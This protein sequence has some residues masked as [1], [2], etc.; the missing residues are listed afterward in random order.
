M[1]PS[2]RISTRTRRRTAAAAGAAPPAVDYGFG[3]GGA[4][5]PSARRVSI[6]P[7]V[8]RSP[9]PL[10]VVTVPAPAASPALT[11]PIPSGP[12]H[13]EPVGTPLL[14]LPP[15]LTP[16]PPQ[17]STWMPSALL[18]NFSSGILP[19]AIRTLTACTSNRPSLRA[20]PPCVTSLLAGRHAYQP[21]VCRVFLRTS[22]PPAQR[23]RSLLAKAGYTPLTTAS[24]CSS[25]NRLRNPC[26]TRSTRWDARLVCWTMIVFTFTYHGSCTVGSC[27]LVIRQ[28]PAISAPRALCE[29]SGVF[30]GGL[31]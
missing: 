17:R 3:P 5:R 1:P 10:A 26:L 31:V 8:P 24:S 18:L 29:C 4:R 27:R 30:P 15:H 11:V 9:S 21:T 13:A 12:D 7:R 20:T 28:L 16:R 19:R 2:G 6:P 14:R 25:V 23:F 22:T